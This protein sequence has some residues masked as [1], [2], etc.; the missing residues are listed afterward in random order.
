MIKIFFLFVVLSGLVGCSKSKDEERTEAIDLAQTYLSD[1]KCSEAIKVLESA[2]SGSNDP[3]YIQ[4]LASAYACK[5]SYS[6]LTFIANDLPNLESSTIKALF[7]SISILTLSNET[8]T[9]SDDYLNLKTALTILTSSTGDSS[10]HD[11]RVSK[12]GVRKAADMGVQIMFLSLVQLG[13]FLNYFGNVDSTGAKGI[14]PD[15]TNSCFLN[16]SNN[17]AQ[18]LIDAF[19]VANSCNSYVD[20][21]GDLDLSTEEGKERACEGLFYF[22]NLLNSISNLDLSASE[23]LGSLGDIAGV[24]DELKNTVTTAYPNLSDLMNNQS[25]SGCVSLLDSAEEIENMEIIYA[26]IFEENL[27]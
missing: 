3:V 12:F 1:A 20:G 24:V 8:D 27:E 17:T 5:S 23:S 14:G 2:G 7:K 11:A 26:M 19:P 22:N 6:E 16:Y 9:D 18:T 25:L 21:H 4:V 10:G 13:K 15:G